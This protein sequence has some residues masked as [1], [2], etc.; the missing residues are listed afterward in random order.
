MQEAIKDAN[1]T[2]FVYL[3]DYYGAPKTGVSDAEVG[4][5]MH[6]SSGTTYLP[7]SGW[8]NWS[9]VGSLPGWYEMEVESASSMFSDLGEGVLRVFPSSSEM[10]AEW[11]EIISVVT[12]KTDEVRRR[13]LGLSKQNSKLTVVTTNALGYMTSGTL[14]IFDDKALTSKITEYTVA[15]NYNPTTGEL[16]DYQ[17]T[18][19]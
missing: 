10:F 9:E 8:I 1:N 18:E 5:T 13:L 12:Y 15:A 16:I 3:E 11:S 4:V 7:P 17:L 14:E 19:V 6:H 2:F